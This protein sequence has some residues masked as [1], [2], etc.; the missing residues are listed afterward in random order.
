[1]NLRRGVWLIPCT[2]AACSALTGPRHDDVSLEVRSVTPVNGFRD[3]RYAFTITN[4]GNRPIFLPTC[5]GRV[6]PEF[7]LEMPGLVEHLSTFC[8]AVNSMV[9]AR[10]EPG[11]QYASSGQVSRIARTRYT[12]YI[13][14]TVGQAGG[15]E[16][17]AMARSFV[18]PSPSGSP[19]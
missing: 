14:F 3:L 10:L 6:R 11:A 7:R 8:L 5:G 9:P 17:R 4:R 13:R 18:A 12:P 16:S 15:T 1:M 19:D 2:V